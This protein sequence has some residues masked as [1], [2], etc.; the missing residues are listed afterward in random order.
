MVRVSRYSFVSLGPD[1]KPSGRAGVRSHTRVPR[2][3][4]GYADA[5]MSALDVHVPTHELDVLDPATG[6]VL[7]RIPQ[8]SAEAADQAVRAAQAA[9]PPWARTAPAQ[10]GAQLKAAAQR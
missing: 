3:G 2:R 10:R 6:E 9:Q 8:G 7:G 1:L 5:S 4:R